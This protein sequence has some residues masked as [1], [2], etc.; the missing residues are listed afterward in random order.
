MRK[1]ALIGTAL[2]FGLTSTAWAGAK[3]KS[4]NTLVDI[5]DEGTIDNTT[6]KTK[7]KSKGCT[8]QIQ[9]TVNLPDGEIVICVAEADVQQTGGLMSP[10]GG[11]GAVVVG[12]AKAGKLKI[13]ADLTEVQILGQACGALDVIQ[14]NGGVRCFR[15]DATYRGDAN[16][17][18]SWRADCADEVGP[19]ASTLPS[20]SELKA[21]SGQPVIP[22]ICQITG[23]GRLEGPASDLIA[24]QGGRV[25]LE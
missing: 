20:E 21:N 9:A 5:D 3:D 10:L 4:S 18:G 25:G 24:V 17:P 12:E 23:G 15:D 19:L 6:A 13:K 16:I 7:I 8:L 1:V 11:N 2:V 14:Y 22:G